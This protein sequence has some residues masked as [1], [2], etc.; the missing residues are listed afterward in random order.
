MLIADT[1][2]QPTGSQVF[3]HLIDLEA[4]GSSGQKFY[5]T[6]TDGDFNL[7]GLA[8][9]KITCTLASGMIASSS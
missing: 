1:I 2:L 4:S 3:D 8:F 7:M 5:R 6:G 9:Q